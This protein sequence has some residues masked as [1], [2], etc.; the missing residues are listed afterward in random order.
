MLNRISQIDEL[1][2]GHP[3]GAHSFFIT[4]MLS[5]GRP[6]GT[7]NLSQKSDAFKLRF[8]APTDTWVLTQG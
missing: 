6:D 2:S 7:G 5:T 8:K 4:S 1:F 3:Y